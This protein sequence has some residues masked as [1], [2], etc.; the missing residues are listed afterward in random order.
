MVSAVQAEH[1]SSTPCV[2]STVE[3]TRVSTRLK[4]H[5][6]QE[7][8][9]FQIDSTRTP[10]RHG[11]QAEEAQLPPEGNARGSEGRVARLARRQAAQGGAEEV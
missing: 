6:F 10:L 7:A 4:V 2:E 1:I 5:P 8:N 3:S 11:A 9:W